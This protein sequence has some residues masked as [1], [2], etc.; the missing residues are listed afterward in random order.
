MRDLRLSEVA[1][2][3]GLHSGAQ[4]ADVGCGG[5]EI[6]LIWSRAVGPSGHVWCED[7]DERYA[8][9]PARALMKK[10]RA[11]N[12]SIIRGDVANPHLPEA[13]LDGISVFWAYH[14]MTKYPEML[15]QVRRA[16]KPDGRLVIL[17]P[18]PQKTA[19][20]PRDIQTKNH[21]LRRDIAENEVRQAGFDIV[22]TDDRFVDNPDSEVLAWMIVARPAK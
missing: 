6:A 20:R 11:K 16:L 1:R 14:E 19:D 21:V 9:K 5:G 12:V 18:T 8:L 22:H 2:Q 13:Q 7:I 3:M 10:Y 17:D 4:V 15:A